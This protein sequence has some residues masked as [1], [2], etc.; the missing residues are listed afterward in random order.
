MRMAFLVAALLC[1]PAFGKAKPKPPP[2]AKKDP[3]TVGLGRRCDKRS[4]CT[5]KSQM[6]MRLI[7]ARGKMQQ[8]G[9]CALPCA[10]LES[11]LARP[12]RTK[13]AAKEQPSTDAAASPGGTEAGS[14]PAVATAPA[15]K[16]Q[17]TYKRVPPR[18]PPRFQCRSAGAGV[19]IDLCVRN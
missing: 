14:P 11:G 7:D 19:P 6:C 12:A 2:A 1:A 10:S 3:R 17:R 4:D 13:A 9:F 8:H 16:P 5:G 15:P 18:C